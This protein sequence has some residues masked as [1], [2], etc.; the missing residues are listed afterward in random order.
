MRQPHRLLRWSFVFAFVLA[1][2]G[3]GDADPPTVD[4]GDA[5]AA[6]RSAFNGHDEAH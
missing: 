5:D 2:C 3:G 6:S 1:A 4:A